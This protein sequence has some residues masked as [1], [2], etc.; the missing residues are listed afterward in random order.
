M[1]TCASG[2]LLTCLEAGAG[3]LHA[4][5]LARQTSAAGVVCRAPDTFLGAHLQTCRKLIDGG[6]IGKVTAAS[7][8]VVSQGTSGSIPVRTSSINQRRTAA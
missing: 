3:V 8:F 7:V 4:L 2:H 6:S 5:T 1:G